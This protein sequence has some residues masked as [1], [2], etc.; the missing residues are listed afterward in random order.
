MRFACLCAVVFLCSA[1]FASARGQVTDTAD[2]KGVVLD[3]TGVPIAAA[4]V[5]LEDSAGRAYR[6][7]T[8]GT[9][10]FTFHELAPGEYKAEV[11]KEGFFVLAGQVLTLHTGINE[12]SLI[13]NHEQEIREQVQVTAP[14]N[15]I[16]TQDTAQRSSLSARDIRDVPVPNV[17][18]LQESLV[19]LPEIVQDNRDNLHVAGARSADTQYLL[20][21]FEIGDPASG[22]LT[23]RFA[24][25]ATRSAEI[26][27]G[28]VGAG[29]AHSGA[30]ILS[31]ETPDGDDRWRFGTT[32]PFPGI[33]V[34][35]GVHLGNWY[36][37]FTFSG[38]I[39]KGRL[40]F[41]DAIGVQHTFAVVKGLPSGANTSEEWAG[42]NLLRLQCNITPRHILHASV[43]Y[44]RAHDDYL[45]LDA[46]D[47]Q[48]TT[49]TA[50][51]RR[52]FVSL[53]DQISLNNI[54][55]E[56]GVAADDGTL[57]YIPQGTQPYVLLINGTS[58]NYFQHLHDR[59][60]RLQ[61]VGGV[62]AVSHRFLGKHQF[63]VG[64]NVAGLRF[65]Q[66]AERGVVDALNYVPPN[67]VNPSPCTSPT[68]P[69][70][71]VRESTFAGGANP[72]LSNTQAGGY[73]Q[74]TWTLSKRFI[75]QPGLRADWD[76]F[77]QSYMT[78]PRLSANFLP[79]ADDRS[80]LSL[81]WGIY[82][83]PLNL[84]LIAQVFDQRQVDTFYGPTGNILPPGAITS[85]FALPASGLRQPRF[86]ISSAGWQQKFAHNTLLGLDLLARNGYHGFA[87]VDQQPAQPGGI[88][89]LQDHRKDRYRSAT[90]SVRHVFSDSMELFG[91]YTRSRAHS[92]EVLNP[93]LG[94]IF[95]AP[96]QSGPLAW[97]APN[98]LLTWGWF[99]THIWSTQLSYFFEYRTGYPFSAVNLQQQLVG[100]PNSLRFPA[101]ASL[102]L[103][104]ERKFAL[105]GYLWG[106]RV[107]S[108]NI[109]G[110]QNPDTVVN[111]VDAPAC[112]SQLTQGC[113]GAFSGGQGRAFTLRVRFAGR[114]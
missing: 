16:E 52:G 13:L 3:E 27:T 114:K 45:G 108:V 15:Q 63:A 69:G 8:D 21:G 103:G 32:N 2:C 64:F 42:D 11:R 7:E 6:A 1:A 31:L 107:E 25:Y 91:A 105:R 49:V 73:V 19:A 48:S 34:Q 76:R 58:G 37:Q 36:P 110:R 90:L 92:N 93:S 65:T 71:L 61:A 95:Y 22:A 67:V 111:N 44:N 9:G 72:I 89:L 43:L 112:T 53:K 85:Q 39:E 79:F 94:S 38:P 24:V 55:F 33:N 82:N 59:G 77:T 70:C 18:I 17:H 96:Q 97:D 60:R 51:Q 104:L 47:P 81:G 88:F 100:L 109:L 56:L 83:A 98:R 28:R 10:H 23:A 14:S 113:Y 101:Y 26:Q 62:T 87:F 20:D 84:S 29:Y 50:E 46:L 41:S 68:M 40:W 75:L 12:V 78:G 80:K 74:D 106:V 102:N 35:E 5:K 57:E 86:T 99:P 30:S 66:S 4:Q 54:L